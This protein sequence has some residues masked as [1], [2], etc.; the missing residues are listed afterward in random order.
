LALAHA[1]T[2]RLASAVQLATDGVA[3]ANAR[4]FGF[5]RLL[6]SQG[7]VLMAAQRLDEAGSVATTALEM[8]RAQGEQGHEACALLLLGEI[9]GRQPAVVEA[10]LGFFD[11]ALALAD[12]LGMRPL[13]AR[14]HLE[15]AEVLSRPGR[16]DQAQPSLTVAVEEF[17]AMEMKEWLRR[18]PR[19]CAKDPRR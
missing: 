18:V 13:R 3:T 9:S 12:R 2:G 10:S 8:A 6:E 1:A 16:H 17:R 14:C 5:V 19:S 7:S 15:R 4:R 11:A